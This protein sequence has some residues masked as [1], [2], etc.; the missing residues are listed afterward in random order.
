MVKHTIYATLFLI[1]SCTYN[2][3]ELPGNTG[4]RPETIEQILKKMAIKKAKS[5]L[6]RIKEMI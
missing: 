4:S 6:D 3:M 2:A 5:E 1:H